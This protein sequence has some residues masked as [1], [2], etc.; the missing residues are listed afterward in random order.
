MIVTITAVI[1]VCDNC[2]EYYGASS[3]GDLRE[4]WNTKLNSDERTFPRSQCPTPVCAQQGIQ[5]RPVNV[6]IRLR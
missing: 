1:W 2:G 4:Q 3:A 6:D 5:R